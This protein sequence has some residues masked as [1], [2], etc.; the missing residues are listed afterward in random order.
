M[1]PE[2]R[3]IP[4]FPGYFAGTDGSI[5]TS[6]MKGGNREPGRRGPL[7]PLRIALARGYCQ[8]AFCVDGKTVVEQVHQIILETFVGPKPDGMESCHYPDPDRTNNRI[9][10]LRWD[11]HAEN[12]KDKYRD[13]DPNSPKRCSR[14]QAYKPR[15]EFYTDKRASDGL[16]VEC[17]PC[18][19]IS[20]KIKR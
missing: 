15:I 7:K 1:E 9:E 19:K 3:E 16:K 13:R 11:T 10:N 17:K 6:K 18:H 12:A 14:C 4:R 8:V 20:A 5:W 2:I